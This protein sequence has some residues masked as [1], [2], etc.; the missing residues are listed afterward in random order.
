MS[1]TSSEAYIK[2]D[3]PQNVREKFLVCNTLDLHSS[4]LSLADGTE[5][6]MYLVGNSLGLQPKIVRR[7]LDE[8]LEKW[9]KRGIRGHTKGAH[10]WAWAEN[11]IEDLM[12]R[13]IGVTLHFSTSCN[14]YDQIYKYYLLR[15]L[16][17]DWCGLITFH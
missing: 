5:E 7:Y 1:P 8:E 16:H 3:K 12:V 13:T 6:C 17:R 11:N 14:M 15:L 9:A 2:L 4:D 10:P